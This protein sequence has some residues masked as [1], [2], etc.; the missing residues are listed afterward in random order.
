MCVGRTED[1]DVSR[2]RTPDVIIWRQD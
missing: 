2:L 1:T